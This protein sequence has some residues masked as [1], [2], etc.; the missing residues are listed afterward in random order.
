MNGVGLIQKF[1]WVK[2][3]EDGYNIKLYN[4]LLYSLIYIYDLLYNR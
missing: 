2:F 3:K 4:M 1:I